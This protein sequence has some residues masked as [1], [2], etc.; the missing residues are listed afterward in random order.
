MNTI[1]LKNGMNAGEV[2][3]GDFISMNLM[4]KKS[5]ISEEKILLLQ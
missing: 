4:Y 5:G 1:V 3:G 2:L